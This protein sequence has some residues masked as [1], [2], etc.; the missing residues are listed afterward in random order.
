VSLTGGPASS[1]HTS[2]AYPGLLA[3][4]VA[5]G[6]VAG[7]AAGL[8]GLALV[9]R[10]IRAGLAVEAA[11]AA[12]AGGHEAIF[13]RNVQVVGG[14]AAAIVVGV[15]L[16]ALFATAYLAAYGRL[17]AGTDF[18]RSVALSL[19]CFAVVGLLPGVKYPANPPGIGDPDTAQ[20][21]TIL[22]L[23][24][25]AAGL[26][27]MCAAGWLR[28]FLAARTSWPAAL[29]T[30]V[31]TA[32]VAGA[33]GA[34]LAIWPAGPDAVPADVPAQLLWDFRL[35]SL[36]EVLTLWAVLGFGF[37]LLVE[38]SASRGSG[39]RRPQSVDRTA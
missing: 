34:V 38:R 6:A 9:A 8:V 17:P 39:A 22:Y 27:V 36:A 7:V 13:G 15:A 25:I 11:R 20:R 32:A 16:G 5:A 12:D 30:T 24:L 23:T 2:L 26:L 35:A 3:R 33:L 1:S 4:G 18:G 21:R 10:P 28:A 19:V 31:A 37:G 14:V 29:R